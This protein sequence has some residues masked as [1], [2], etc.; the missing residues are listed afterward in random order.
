M[1][2]LTGLEGN[3][4]KWNEPGSMTVERKKNILIITDNFAM[5]AGSERNITQLM[6]GIDR[7]KFQIFVA[8]FLTGKLADEMREQGFSV[9]TLHPRGVHTFEGL[10]NLAFLRRMIVN[11]K[12]SLLVTYHENSDVYGLVLSRICNIPIISNRRDMGYK[13]KFRHKLLYR[14]S[15][16]FYDA[17]I[18]VCDAIKA[19]VVKRRWFPAD[20]ISC[21]YN[22]V[23]L[24]KFGITRDNGCLRREVGIDLVDPVVG[25]IGNIRRIKGIEYFIEAASIVLK[26]ISDVEFLIIGEDFKR[27]GYARSDLELLGKKLG[28]SSRIHF[29]SKRN[30]VVELIS[31]FDVGVVPSLSEGFSNVIL[32]YMA[33]SKPVVA[34]NVGGNPEAVIHGETGFLVPPGDSVALGEAISSM[35]R[36]SE[37]RQRFGMAGRRRAENQFSLKGMLR[38]YEEVFE[39]SLRLKRNRESIKVI[40]N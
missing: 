1:G 7:D 14:S 18:T 21:I 26:R 37:M 4:R 22:G 39:R 23:D 38:G 20:K 11:N 17:V 15:G 28:V 32:E 31:I 12:I 3:D 2:S 19:E 34:T 40:E 16:R 30:D 13:T 36:D 5:M 27:I 10:K 9:F 24:S 6:T 25:F 8:S 33:S 29:I 35:L